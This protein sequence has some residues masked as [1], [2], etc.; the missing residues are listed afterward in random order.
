MTLTPSSI[1]NIVLEDIN[2]SIDIFQPSAVKNP[3]IVVNC[4]M[5]AGTQGFVDIFLGPNNTTRTVAS[6]KIGF[7]APA[8]N[9]NSAP[10]TCPITL[11]A[12]PAQYH[13]YVTI[14]DSKYNI[15]GVG[16]WT[17]DT[18]IFT[19]TIGNITWS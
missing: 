5:Q 8:A 10:I 1:A 15:L 4:N 3:T 9:T 19:A 18:V 13:V 11:P 12:T 7:T 6:A 2:M 16:Q 17:N 14:Y